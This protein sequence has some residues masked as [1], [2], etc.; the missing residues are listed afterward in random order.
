[1]QEKLGT[2]KPSVLEYCD[3]FWNVFNILNME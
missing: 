1:M 3:Q 2:L